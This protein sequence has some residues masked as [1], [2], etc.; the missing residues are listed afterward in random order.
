MIVSARIA[1]AF[2]P[3]EVGSAKRSSDSFTKPTGRER[4][5]VSALAESYRPGRISV[6]YIRFAGSST[7]MMCSTVL[8]RS[9]KA[10]LKKP[11]TS[12]MIFKASS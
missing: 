4:Q 5:A 6:H 11:G 3:F 8:G 1:E 12:R 10:L 9:T 2:S 7:W